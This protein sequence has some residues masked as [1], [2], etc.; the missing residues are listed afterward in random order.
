MAAERAPS[1]YRVKLLA[2]SSWANWCRDRADQANGRER[3][4]GTR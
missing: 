2:C 1:E 3:Y 4:R